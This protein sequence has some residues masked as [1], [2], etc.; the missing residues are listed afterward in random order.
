MGNKIESRIKNVISAVFDIPEGQIKDDSSS[1]TIESWDSIR[2]M[3]LIIALEEEFQLQFN[4]VQTL[5][6]VNYSSI[7]KILKEM[8]K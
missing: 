7:Y 8:L 4:D 5:E 6:I 2:H 1:D 3:N